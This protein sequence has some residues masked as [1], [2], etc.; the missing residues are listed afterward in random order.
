MTF[1][2]IVLSER[3]V[4]GIGTEAKRLGHGTEPADPVPIPMHDPPLMVGAR[5]KIEA[6]SAT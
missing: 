4:A 5:A 3:I 2:Q 1:T 6:S